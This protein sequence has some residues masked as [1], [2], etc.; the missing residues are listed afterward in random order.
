MDKR[1]QDLA[2]RRDLLQTFCGSRSSPTLQRQHVADKRRI[3]S[4]EAQNLFRKTIIT[5]LA[6]LSTGR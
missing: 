5:F 3:P 4:L 2:E 1:L 6:L